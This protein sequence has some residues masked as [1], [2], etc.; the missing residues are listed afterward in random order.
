MK[1]NIVSINRRHIREGIRLESTSCPIAQAVQEHFG[2]D[3]WRVSVDAY[4]RVYKKPG[5]MFAYKLY[6]VTRSSERF[7]DKFDKTGKGKPF[8]MR[9]IEVE[10]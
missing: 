1:S 3:M 2:P 5:D 7:M 9:L 8:R 10:L 6:K 4:I